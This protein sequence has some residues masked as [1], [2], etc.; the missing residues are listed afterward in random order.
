MGPVH[1]L[2][3]KLG[4]A[5]IHSPLF[6]RINRY[7]IHTMLKKEN[8]AITIIVA[9]IALISIGVVIFSVVQ[10][11][12]ELKSNSPE[13]VVQSYLTAVFDGKFDIAITSLI[14]TSTCTAE[15]L[16]RTY[17]QDSSQIHLRSSEDNGTTAQVNVDVETPDGSPFGGLMSEKHSYRLSKING[18]WKISGIPWPLYDCGVR[19][20]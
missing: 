4:A 16:D 17:F 18:Q 19:T 2:A 6:K 3:I 5:S 15:D 14:P 20:K 9:L 11:V 12:K 8:R 10:P 13:A 7:D 1:F